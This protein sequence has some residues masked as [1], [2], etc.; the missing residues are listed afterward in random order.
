MRSLPF[1]LAG[2]KATN[3]PYRLPVRSIKLPIQKVYITIVS[4]VKN[5]DTIESTVRIAAWLKPELVMVPSI[6]NGSIPYLRTRMMTGT[7]AE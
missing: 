4:N 2:S 3:R 7:S 5:Y 6:S 1:N